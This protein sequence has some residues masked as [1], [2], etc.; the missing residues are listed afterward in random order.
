MSTPITIRKA[1]RE[2]SKAIF[3][4]IQELAIYENGLD[5]VSNSV[6]QLAQDGF[7]DSPLFECLVGTKKG[8]VI[9]ISL[10]YYRYSTWRGKILYLEDLIV[11]QSERGQG[12]GKQLLDA[13]IEIAKKTQCKGM[14]WQ[15]LDWN[16]PAIDFYKQYAVE[17]DGEWLNV[18]T[19]F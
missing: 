11:T 18:E 17:F 15:V 10:Y 5:Q 13:T 1:I 2:D 8:N 12:Y 14:R 7:G 19:F 9:G 3:E 16:T 4:L 6:E